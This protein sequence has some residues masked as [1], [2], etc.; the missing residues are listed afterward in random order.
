MLTP[1]VTGLSCPF[2]SGAGSRVRGAVGYGRAGGL[3]STFLMG[4][5]AHSLG[6][7]LLMTHLKKKKGWSHLFPPSEELRCPQS[8]KLDYFSFPVVMK[9]GI[10]RMFEA[11]PH[12]W[13]YEWI[14]L[15]SFWVV[16]NQFVLHRNAIC[17]WSLGMRLE[18]SLCLVFVSLW[19]EILSLYFWMYFT[20]CISMSLFPKSL[21]L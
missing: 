10:S 17:S 6:P 21:L 18:F 20:S 4:A 9:I 19:N 1:L 13:S 11:K 8:K 14:I 3:R 2:H 12:L 15:I 5:G 16:R 7:E